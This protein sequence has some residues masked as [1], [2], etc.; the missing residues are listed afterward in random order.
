MGKVRFH[1]IFILLVQALKDSHQQVQMMGLQVSDVFLSASK[2]SNLGR[3]GT[4][5]GA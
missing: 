5:M 3:G 2:M 4:E 1:F